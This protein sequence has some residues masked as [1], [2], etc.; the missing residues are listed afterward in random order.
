MVGDE[1]RRFFWLLLTSFTIR[2][3][4]PYLWLVICRMQPTTT[5]GATKP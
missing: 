3:Q 5:P 4:S 1:G 2:S